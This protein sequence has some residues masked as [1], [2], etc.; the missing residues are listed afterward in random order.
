[1]NHFHNFWSAISYENVLA[2]MTQ[3]LLSTK[4]SIS[5]YRNLLITQISPMPHLS[6]IAILT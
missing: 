2:A 4:V 5:S 1:M 3:I 6:T